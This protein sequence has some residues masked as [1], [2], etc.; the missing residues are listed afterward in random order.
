M[1]DRFKG[2][3]ILALFTIIFGLNG[4]MSCS[5]SEKGSETSEPTKQEDTASS[6]E[7]EDLNLKFDMDI[8]ATDSLSIENDSL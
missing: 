6:S 7:I 4:L 1:E 8:E 2:L 5:G 3:L